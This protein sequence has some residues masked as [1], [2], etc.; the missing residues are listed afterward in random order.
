MHFE[1]ATLGFLEI[2][3]WGF[4]KLS[5][6][7]FSNLTESFEAWEYRHRVRPRLRSLSRAGLIVL[8]GRGQ[9]QTVRVTSSGRLLVSGGVDPEA[10]WR[11]TWDG[12]W[13]LVLFDLAGGR[14]RL[15]MRLWR[16]L[17]AQRLG[18]LQNSVWVS[19]DPVDDSLLPLKH[20]KLTP[21]SYAV[22][23]GRPTPPDADADLVQGAW[24]FASINHAYAKAINV[25]VEGCE[26]ARRPGTTGAERQKW[27]TMQ[28]SAW[29]AAVRLDPLLPAS[30]CPTRY[31]GREAWQVRMEAFAGVFAIPR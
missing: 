19:P 1:P 11:R 13:R 4:G 10:R 17:R 30:L 26:M 5:R 28:R 9:E 20:L 24:D 15:R 31:L 7:S 18:Y 21:E 8:Q 3:C 22:I 16:W 23:E 6:P 29:W 27:L 12:K 25:A 14:S 2:L